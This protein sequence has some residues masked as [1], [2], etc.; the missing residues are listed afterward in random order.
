MIASHQRK[1]DPPGIS[2]EWTD[3]LVLEFT[4][5]AQQGSLSGDFEGCK[6]MV[7]KLKR[8]RIMQSESLPPSKPPFIPKEPPFIP[9]IV[10]IE[11]SL[12]AIASSIAALIL[13]AD[14]FIETLNRVNDSIIPIDVRR[15]EE[16]LGKISRGLP[17]N[18]DAIDGIGNAVDA[19][20]RDFYNRFKG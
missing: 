15:I 2:I 16:E 8:F 5:R 17:A 1:D 7:S 10:D 20:R 11:I 14:E 18:W 19:L 12:A 3:D 13:K 9:P 6:S 4:R